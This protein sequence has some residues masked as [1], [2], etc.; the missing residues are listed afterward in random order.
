MVRTRRRSGLWIARRPSCEPQSFRRYD[1]LRVVAAAATIAPGA[2]NPG[3]TTS[4][5]NALLLACTLP[6]PTGG[7]LSNDILLAFLGIDGIPGLSTA[8]AGWVELKDQASGTAVK[9]GCYYCRAAGGETGTVQFDFSASEGGAV[10]IWCIR[11]AHTTSA[12]E[13][14][15]GVAATTANPD[16]D[17]LTASWGAEDNL[18]F[19]ATAGDAPA[20]P[21]AGPAGYS[22]FA[23]HHWTSAGSG[24]GIATAWK[25]VTAAA[26]DDPGPFTRAAEDSL[27]WTTVIRPAAAGAAA[28][29]LVIPRRAHRGLV[30]QRRR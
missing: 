18:F 10:H 29:S 8:A 15:A 25:A 5:A 27:A 14:S 30:M 21:T 12:P 26:T 23:A 7:I 20:G 11:G 3:A 1:P 19:A 6:A 9:A 2:T 22:G 24:A 16:P 4:A 17:S 13:V 28:T